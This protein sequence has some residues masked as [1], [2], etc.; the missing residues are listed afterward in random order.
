MDLGDE[1][2]NKKFDQFREYLNKTWM[3]EQA[4]FDRSIWNF[5]NDEKSRT[6]NISETYQS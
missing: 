5:H 4:T 3:S 2:E 6:N 1:L